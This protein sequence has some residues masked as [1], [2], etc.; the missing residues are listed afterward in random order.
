MSLA[1]L[2]ERAAAERVPLAI[3]AAE[4]LHVVLLD[5]LF[6]HPNSQAMAFQ[7]G[8][9]LHLIHGGYRYSEDLDLAGQDLDGAAA[10]E[11]IER[12]RSEVERLSIQ[13]MGPGQP[14]WK[15][16]ARPS[17]LSTYWFHFTPENTRQK[18]RVKIEF[19]RFPTY[20]PA[21]LPVQSEFDFL[22]RRPLVT[23]LQPAELLAE[24]VTA[25]LGRSYLKARD[26]FDLWFLNDVLQAA[27]EPQLLKRKLVDYGVVSTPVHVRERIASAAA[28]DIGAEME[29][30]LP[31]RYRAQLAR[32]GYEAVRGAA[33]KVLEHAAEAVDLA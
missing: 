25:V 22:H 29:R 5:A 19:A 11:I 27:L 4:A 1:A 14:T 30:F 32:G 17:R 31:Q 12:A 6:A 16:P 28:A 20:Q 9:C 23:A 10:G 24:K 8:T 13:V 26:L 18:I 33:R 21:V 3:V 7:G 2:R 15:T